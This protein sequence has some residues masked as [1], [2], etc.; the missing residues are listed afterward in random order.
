MPASV[1]PVP[2]ADATNA[3]T[4]TSGV[5]PSAAARLN[6]TGNAKAPSGTEALLNAASASGASQVNEKLKQ[7]LEENPSLID[8]VDDTRFFKDKHL[9]PGLEC[10]PMD[11]EEL[12]VAIEVRLSI[13]WGRQ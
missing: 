11:A 12:E 9:S 6:L 4:S 2:S 8:V 7:A 3:D 1:T 13:V 10:F 5:P